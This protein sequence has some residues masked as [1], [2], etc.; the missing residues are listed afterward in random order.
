MSPVRKVDAPP[1]R[2]AVAAASAALAALVVALALSADRPRKL[3]TPPSAEEARRAIGATG[4]L[5]AALAGA[6]DPACDFEP[7]PLPDPGDWLARHEERGQTFAEFARSRRSGPDARRKVI[8][9]QPL[10]EFPPESSPSIETLERFA[11]AFFSLEVKALEPLDLAK[12]RITS[13]EH[14]RYRQLLTTD[15]LELLERR[16]PGDACA[17]VGITMIDLYPDPAWN[18]VFGQAS[19]RDRVGVFSFARYLPERGSPDEASKR[20]LLRRSLRV[21]AHE[22]GHMLGIH[23]CIW[24]RCLMN[25]SNHLAESDSQP[26]HLCP[27]DLRKLH[28]SAAFDPLARYRRLAK[29]HEEAENAAEARWLRGRIARIEALPAGEGGTASAPEAPP[30][31]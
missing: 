15:I 28:R 11:E 22:T 30:K 9:L 16:L 24:Y 13:R 27:V 26:L 19:L 17:A 31:D 1:P 20:L 4:D 14:G 10:G 7:V 5:P 2:I 3:F 12:E 18:F 8:Y 6:L 25:G 21:L 29:L 23:H